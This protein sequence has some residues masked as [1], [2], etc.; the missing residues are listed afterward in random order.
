MDG[1]S[2]SRWVPEIP[3]PVNPAPVPE[4]LWTLTA[5]VP[6]IPWTLT[7]PVPEIPWTL[8]APAGSTP[9]GWGR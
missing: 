3:R 4:I 2:G 7:A 6:E 1:F 5:P 8:T 9:T